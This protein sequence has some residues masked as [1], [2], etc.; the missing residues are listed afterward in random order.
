MTKPMEKIHKSYSIAEARKPFHAIVHET[1]KGPVALTRDG[2][3]VVV[4]VSFAEYQR[5][6]GAF[7]KR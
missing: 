2:E 3:P 1:E 4:M 7:E 6:V 5:L